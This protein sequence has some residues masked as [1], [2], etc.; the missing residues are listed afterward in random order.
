MAITGEEAEKLAHAMVIELACSPWSEQDDVVLVGSEAKFAHLERV[1]HSETVTDVVRK[2]ER[3][4]RERKSLLEIV[5][6][7][8]NGDTRWVE[9]GD[10]WDLCVVFC[11]PGAAEKEPDAVEALIDLAGDGSYGLVVITLSHTLSAR[12]RVQVDGGPIRLDFR[13]EELSGLRSL[14]LTPQRVDGPVMGQISS[15]M[16]VA[17]DFQGVAPDSPPYNDAA[18]QIDS[19]CTRDEASVANPAGDLNSEVTICVLGPIEILGAARPFTRAWAEELVVYLAMHRRLGATTDQWSTALWPERILAPASLH[20][21]ASSAR[22][23]LGVS[24]T[25]ED[26]LP[27][28][29]GRLALGDGVDSD[30]DQ[31]V[32]YSRSSRP[33]DWHNALELI[34]GRPFDRLRAPDWTLL[35]GITA[36]IEA[37]VVDLACRHSERCLSDGDWRSAE[38]AARQG[39]LVSSY[40]ERLYRVLMRSSDASGNPAGVEAVMSEL[41]HL[42]SDEVEP[43]DAVHPETLELYRSLSRRSLAPRRR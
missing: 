38:W 22:R 14:A 28:S 25:G 33:E 3:R 20:S 19:S 37:V 39:L 15:L 17:S 34:R 32:R 5:R 31:F 6:S 18:L 24:R 10:A 29:H 23:A 2:L 12:T 43:F 40:D 30:W 11:M 4:V 8:S 1:S 26:H 21:T 27:R 41:V 7:S 16:D 35:E 36:T 9:G 13:N 42:V